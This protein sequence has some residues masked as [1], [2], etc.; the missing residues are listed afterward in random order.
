MELR[1]PITGTCY[2]LR[3]K[4]IVVAIDGP[5][6]AGKSTV[7]KRLAAR[8]GYQLLDTGAIYRA[9]ALLGRRRGVDWADEAGL[10]AI[11]AGLQI[12]FRIEGEANRIC[13]D[14]E[15]VTD[16]IR[17]PEMSDGASRVSSL[18]GVRAALLD[19]QRRLGAHGGV[20]AEGRDIGTV[21]FPA[22]E[23]K[24][25]LTATPEERARRRCEELRAKGIAADYD[26]TLAE[27]RIRDD[28]DSN[29]AVAPLVQAADAILVDSTHRSV[30][31]IV[32]G[33]VA[34]VVQLG[35][36]G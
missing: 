4:P 24:F 17:T 10:A 16:A 30:D 36:I 13:N 35:G 11:A 23:A 8:L 15:E 31:E 25:F 18:P 7:T 3:V 19:L 20:V 29:R 1:Q 2:V 6:G 21:V 12:S 27:I 26:A 33:M 28:R 34:R 32:E 22:A 9:V 5:A 14:G